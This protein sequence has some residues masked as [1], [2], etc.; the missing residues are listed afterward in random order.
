MALLLTSSPH[1]HRW[2]DQLFLRH[3]PADP[4]QQHFQQSEFARRQVDHLLVD[5]RDASD[6]IERQ[7]PM[8]HD[9]RSAARA[10]ARERTH[11]GFQFVE[12]ERLGHVVVS[13]EIK[14][15]HAFVDAVGGAQ[16]QHGEVRIAGPQA[17]QAH[18]GRTCAAGRDRGSGDRK[19]A[20]TAPYPR[21]RRCRRDRRHRPTGGVIGRDRPRVCCRLRQSEFA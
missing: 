1:S 17:A 16:D 13:A 8:P 2:F 19:S 6:L 4:L 15:F 14:A 7:R 11:A 10:P 9:R 5:I 3:Q 20:L 21:R 18:R 12:G